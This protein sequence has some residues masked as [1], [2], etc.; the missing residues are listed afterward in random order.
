MLAFCQLNA[1]SQILPCGCFLI[2]DAGY[3]TNSNILLPYPSVFAPSNQWFNFI[4]SA[5]WIVVVH[6]AKKNLLNCLPACSSQA[7]IQTPQFC[8]CM[9][10]HSHC[11][12]FT[13]TVDQSLVE[14][15]L[16]NGWS[17]ASWEF[18]HV[19]CRHLNPSE[20]ENCDSVLFTCKIGTSAQAKKGVF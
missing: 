11:A 19:S 15:L 8:I 7:A 18:L 17:E 3:P 5:T 9:F 1:Q 2:G 12:V 6:T 10:W 13:V 14:S 16:E 20:S 4:Q